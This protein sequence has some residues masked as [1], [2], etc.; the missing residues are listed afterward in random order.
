MDNN[1]SYLSADFYLDVEPSE[2]KYMIRNKFGS[3]TKFCKAYG[4]AYRT[5]WK[6]LNDEGVKCNTA[7]KFSAALEEEDLFYLDLSYKEKKIYA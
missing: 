5:V 7:A 6:I 2:V 1:I 4:F 3:L